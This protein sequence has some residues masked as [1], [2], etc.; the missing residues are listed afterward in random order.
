MSLEWSNPGILAV[1]GYDTQVSMI[2][3]GPESAES[4]FFEPVPDY[5]GRYAFT[6][7]SIH[8]S[9]EIGPGVLV[10]LILLTLGDGISAVTLGPRLEERAAIYDVQG[11]TFF[12]EEIS[13][14]QIAVGGASCPAETDAVGGAVELTA[15]AGGGPDWPLFASVAAVVALL[16]SVA[17]V[18]LRR[19]RRAV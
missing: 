4:P 15:D 17:S 6:D 3:Q 2:H 11:D 1:V 13:G 18:Y 10:R 16:A 8:P 9:G 5:D 19:S 12:A 7:V 14:A